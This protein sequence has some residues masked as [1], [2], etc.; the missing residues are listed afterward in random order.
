MLGAILRQLVGGGNITE[1]MGKAFEDAIA[2]FGWV[3]PEALKLLK[4]VETA[5]VR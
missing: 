2:K 1:D 4:T 3:S 5:I